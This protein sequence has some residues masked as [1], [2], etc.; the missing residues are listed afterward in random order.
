MQSTQIQEA[1]KTTQLFTFPLCLLLMLAHTVQS[2]ASGRW[3]KKT[4]NSCQRFTLAVFKI[5]C[6]TVM[7]TN[8]FQIIC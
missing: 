5:L 7:K 8:T 3:V 4:Q 2:Q 6:R 1:L